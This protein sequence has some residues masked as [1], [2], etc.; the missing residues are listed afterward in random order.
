MNNIVPKIENK[1]ED[2]KKWR[3]RIRKL[4]MKSGELTSNKEK[5]QKEKTD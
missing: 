4:E 2:I 3:K 1:Y 5:V